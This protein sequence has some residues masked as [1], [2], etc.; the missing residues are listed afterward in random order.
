[1]SMLAKA[2][3]ALAL[4]FGALLACVGVAGG[5][6]VCTG[7]YLGYVRSL[8]RSPDVFLILFVLTLGGA[9]SVIFLLLGVRA[10]RFGMRCFRAASDGSGV[11][12]P[13]LQTERLRR[14][15]GQVIHA[16]FG[17]QVSPFAIV[18]M[19][20]FAA[21]CAGLVCTALMARREPGWVWGVL[22]CAV[23]F[24][25]MT[26]WLAWKLARQR[27][28][29]NSVCNLRTMPAYIGEAFE[30]EVTVEFPQQKGAGMPDLPTGPVE[31]ALHNLVATGRSVTVQWDATEWVSVESLV[32][33]GDGT[34]RIPV[35][36]DLPLAVL[37]RVG[38]RPDDFGRSIWRLRVRAPYPGVD[39]LAEFV[40]PVRLPR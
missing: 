16:S 40:V 2:H 38:F 28:F 17:N 33:P 10:I 6:L 11:A 23:G 35:R 22:T 36:I 13:R 31:T 25:A 20:L 14:G 39:Y 12:M 21:G 26:A 15:E 8:Y 27:R 4:L 37:D 24:I 32:R 1:M 7:I 3:G 18:S 29:G 5:F 34:L 30:A 9:L 19:Y